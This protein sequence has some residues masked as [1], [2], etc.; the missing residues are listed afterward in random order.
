MFWSELDPSRTVKEHDCIRLGQISKNS[1]TTIKNT[2]EPMAMAASVERQ[3]PRSKRVDRGPWRLYRRS[4]Q[5]LGAPDREK[6]AILMCDGQTRLKCKS[7]KHSATLGAREPLAEK[8]KALKEKGE[9]HAL[10]NRQYR[11]GHPWMVRGFGG[12]K[13]DPTQLSTRGSGGERKTNVIVC[14]QSSKST[15]LN[16]HM[17]L[18]LEEPR[19]DDWDCAW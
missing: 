12:E 9:T 1:K 11:S 16:V 8:Q 15:V 10:E 2:P 13:S 14:H 5:P 7:L 19:S 3:G 17:T 6:E 4:K 18:D